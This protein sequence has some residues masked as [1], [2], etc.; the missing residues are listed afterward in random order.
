M[1]LL[2]NKY[3]WFQTVFFILFVF[4]AQAQEK[5]IRIDYPSQPAT[6]SFVSTE[7]QRPKIGLALSGGG[8]RG[9]AQIG[10]LKV[11][12][13]ENIPIDYIA[14]TSMGG[15]IGG[16]YASGYSAS[17]LER[18]AQE[19]EW[20][21]LLSDTP[22]RLSLFLTQREEREGALFEIRFDGLTP[23]IP[24]AL[25]SG[26]K[27]SNLLTNLTMRANLLARSDFENLKIPFR[28]VTTDLV[29][30][31]EVVLKSGDLS[32][33]MRATMAVPLA[34]SPVEKEGMLLVDGGL[35]DPVPVEV[36]KEMGADIVVAINTSSEL[37]PSDKIKNPFDI[38][39]QATSIMSL[40]KKNQQLKKADLVISPE[41][42]QFS[43]IDFNRADTL[44]KIGETEALKA[45]KELKKSMEK[46]SQV[47]DEP[48]FFFIQKV[49]FSGNRED[50]TEYLS[51]LTQVK[52]NSFTSNKN[53]ENDLK[54]LYSS[55]NFQRVSAE[56]SQKSDLY[57][58]NYQ[59]KE[60]PKVEKVV[61]ENNT[62]YPDTVL[63]DIIS[64]S[65]GNIFNSKK[66]ENDLKVIRDLYQKDGYSL[67]DFD[68]IHYDPS[69][70]KLT[71][72][73]DE[74]I[75]S[76]IKIEGNKRTK[77]WVIRRNFPQKAGQPYNS[78]KI[79]QG[80][81]NI[82]GTG[83]FEKVLLSIEKNASGNVLKIKITEKIF[84]FVRAGAHY[85]DEY[86]N[87]GFLQ[88]VDSNILGIGN[89]IFTHFQYGDK[90]Q[91]YSLNFKADRIMKT[92][93]TYK[94]KLYHTWDKKNLYERYE[95]KESFTQKKTGVHFSFGQHIKRL[96]MASLEGKYERAK[97]H[98]EGSNAYE[99]YNL[100]IIIFRSLVDTFDKYPFPDEGKYHHFYFEIVGKYLGGDKD[101]RKGFSSLESYF[102]LSER[103]NF[104]PKVAFGLS[105][106]LPLSEKFTLGGK[107]N[108]YGFLSEELKG[109]KLFYFNLG[110]RFKFP[111]K[112][113]LTLRYDS[114]NVWSNTE[115]IKLKNLKQ[116]IGGGIAVLT[117]L[118]PVQFD[119]GVAEKT[120]RF[121]FNLGFD[122]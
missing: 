57:S 53:I 5:I 116:G 69:T 33:A 44:I 1:R 74:G 76:D 70:R 104:H 63:K 65:S 64:L 87:E 48:D 92:Y 30:G 103:L 26:Q 60:N 114:G 109:D 79:N 18:I 67:I 119:Y 68:T 36:V 31:S 58:L 28:A 83:L 45:I 50:K 37:L 97:I 14:G 86:K 38:A 42:S 102:P 59:L 54:K 110:L 20:S 4:Q 99:N 93:L 47:K 106:G 11:F 8:A 121:Y 90:R 95:I 16:L 71:F 23:Y 9:F 75:I 32:E 96:G 49:S 117:P 10:I 89:E 2:K 111:Y 27:I 41:L 6:E 100:G 112:I 61:F 29:T 22:P 113:Y 51:R 62:I 46:I 88:F 25:T 115:Q 78:K 77:S 55:G 120:N 34:L 15:I 91:R 40:E 43:S 56:L 21:N 94:L 81:S 7:P 85:K 118:G 3:I 107:Q 66:L 108:F 52:E 39:N 12:E 73:L 19:V 122:F 98:P 35:V 72:A 82:Y 84:D 13:K 101:Y 17:D 80:L 24:K 105:N